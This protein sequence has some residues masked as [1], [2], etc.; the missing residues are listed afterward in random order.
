[1]QI[2]QGKHRK[3]CTKGIRI[4]PFFF[5]RKNWSY[6]QKNLIILQLNAC[7]TQAST[8]WQDF[9]ATCVT[10]GLKGKKAEKATEN[11]LWNVNIVGYLTKILLAAK[12]ESET[13]LKQVNTKYI[14]MRL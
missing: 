11:F 12:K 2:C 5:R 6:I 1:M 13:M 4:P 8:I 9:R 3:R 7:S 14:Y 10:A